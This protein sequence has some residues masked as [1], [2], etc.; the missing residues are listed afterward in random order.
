MRSPVH[1]LFAPASAYDAIARCAHHCAPR[2][3]IDA[4]LSTHQL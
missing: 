4:H 1:S 2:S 3:P